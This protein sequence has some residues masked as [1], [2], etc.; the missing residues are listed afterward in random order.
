M[1]NQHKRKSI[2]I[3]QSS[4]ILH[5]APILKARNILHGY[6]FLLKIG[7]NPNMATKMLRGKAVQLNFR[8][9]TSLCLHLNCTPNDLFALRDLTPP[10]GHQLE[11]LQTLTDEIVN[12]MEKFATM[13]LEEIKKTL[14]NPAHSGAL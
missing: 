13:S 6:A 5:L 10:P 3:P 1:L 7:F 12:P 9:L 11:K 8:Q 14:P 2:S 4:I